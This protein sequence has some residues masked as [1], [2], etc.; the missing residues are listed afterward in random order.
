MRPLASIYTPHFHAAAQL[1][2]KANGASQMS[3]NTS[4]L[5]PRLCETE[6]PAHERKM[7]LGGGMSETAPFSSYTFP[8]M[9]PDVLA[10]AEC[11][12]IR[13]QLLRFGLFIVI[14]K[15]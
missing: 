5:I 12:N 3:T 15:P 10:M 2:M 9:L 14:G 11:E 8:K 7:L 1:D 4:T 6:V 13:V